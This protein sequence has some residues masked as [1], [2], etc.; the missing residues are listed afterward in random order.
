MSPE[1][2][3]ALR[4]SIAK[5][6]AIVDGTGNDDSVH[7]CPLCQ[8]FYDKDCRGC[9]VYDRSGI[10][11]CV[12]TPYVAWCKLFGSDTLP[13]GKIAYSHETKVAAQAELDFLISLL[14][15]GVEP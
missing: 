2:L 8:Q 3:E 1:T 12:G 11:C 5:W 4:G 14:P 13:A 7:N 6:R 10:R 15:E 9:P